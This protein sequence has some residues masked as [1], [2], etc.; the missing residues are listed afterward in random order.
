MLLEPHL[1]ISY[2]RCFEIVSCECKV[3]SDFMVGND[4]L[5]SCEV[6]LLHTWTHYNLERVC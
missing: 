3:G 6:I 2:T 1:A 4:S 5:L